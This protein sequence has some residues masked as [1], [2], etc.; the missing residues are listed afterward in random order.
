MRKRTQRKFTFS[1]AYALAAV[2]VLWGVQAVLFPRHVQQRVSYTAFLAELRH[3]QS[4]EVELR[5]SQIVARLRP[6][7]AVRPGQDVVVTDRLPGINETPLLAEMQRHGV[8][9]SGKIAGT[10]WWQTALSFLLP[11]LLIVFYVIGMRRFAA[12]GPLSVGKSRA[13]IYDPQQDRHVTLS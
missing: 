9:F 5:E 10:P 3:D 2:L 12:G 11:V 4:A 13:Q 8:T 7:P 6:A 1:G